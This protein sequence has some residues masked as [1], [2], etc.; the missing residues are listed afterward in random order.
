VTG[1]SDV[2]LTALAA[3][4]KAEIPEL[5]VLEKWPDP[6]QKLVMPALSLIATGERG[7][8]HVQPTIFKTLPVTG[9]PDLLDVVYTIGEFGYKL[10][11]D[12][13]T[14]YG[15]QRSD[16]I[17]KIHNALNKQFIEGD[18]PCGLSLTL[19]EYYDLIARFDQVGYT[20]LD[21]EESSQ[22]SEWRVKIDVNVNH[23]RLQVKRESKML[24]IQIHDQISD[25]IDVDSADDNSLK[26]IEII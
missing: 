7:Y 9:N 13:W 23:D 21:S 17:D 4:L 18:S 10:Q 26:E 5:S 11:L 16:L 12:L 6:K 22:R 15:E 25:T 24:D 19:T 3:Y 20:Y 2:A 1:S 8:N 14:E